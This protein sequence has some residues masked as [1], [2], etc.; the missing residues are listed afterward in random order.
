MM[1]K[2]WPEYVKISFWVFLAILAVGFG[3]ILP[4]MMGKDIFN[5]AEKKQPL[6]Y[7]VLEN[8]KLIQKDLN[9][10][11]YPG[12][13]PEMIQ[14]ITFQNSEKSDF[15]LHLDDTIK[16]K[17]TDGSHLTYRV[18]RIYDRKYQNVCY[19]LHDNVMSCVHQKLAPE[20]I[21]D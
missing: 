21:K 17:A 14:Q 16:I 8:G 6:N 12:L 18:G 5:K 7:Y 3:I 2:D 4:L 15:I 9:K 11:P 20:Q 19:F 1:K 13:T 10:D